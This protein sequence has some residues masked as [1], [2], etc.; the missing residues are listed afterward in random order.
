MSE[1][2]TKQTLPAPS[3]SAMPRI[4]QAIHREVLEIWKYRWVVYSYVYTTTKI[5]YKRSYLGYFWTV[6]GPMTHYVMIGFVMGL[7]L[8]SRMDNYYVHYFTGALFFSIV[9]G[10][11]TKAPSVMLS[12]E[13]FIRKIYVPKTIFLLNVVSY[14]LVNFT[15]SAAGLLILG[16]ATGFL[17]LSWAFPISLL[18][19][20]LTGLFLLGIAA[21]LSVL[22][23]YFRDFGHITP[24]LVQALFF[25]TPIAYNADMLPPEYHWLPKINPIY[26]FLE[27]VRRPLMD[28]Q[29][30]EPYFFAVASGLAVVSLVVGATVLRIFDNKIIFKL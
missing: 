3:P 2:V 27:I 17:H 24:V 13:H 8:K 26:Y 4:F 20:G 28:G 11:L 18:G 14:E 12:N 29:V 15:F 7:L 9:A 6:L 1:A 22:T 10:I 23:V 30:P 21:C 19:L 25:L 5:R 16:L